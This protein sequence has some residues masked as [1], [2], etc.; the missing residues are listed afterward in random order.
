MNMNNINFIPSPDRAWAHIVR[1]ALYK[2]YDV[3]SIERLHMDTNPIA[4]VYPSGFIEQRLR[5]V[6]LR[7]TMKPTSAIG[8]HVVLPYHFEV[9]NP[10]EIVAKDFFK[11]TPFLSFLIHPEMPIIY[12]PSIGVFIGKMVL[13]YGSARNHDG[14]ASRYHVASVGVSDE[15]LTI[16]CKDPL[17]DPQMMVNNV[18]ERLR[19]HLGLLYVSF[20]M[21]RN[22]SQN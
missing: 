4:S 1:N 15:G 16:E 11:S 21:L 13:T 22:S 3:W 8:T 7:S 9:A 2:D 5:L 17:V 10:R 14:H 20:N 6:L 18:C 12:A 19:Y